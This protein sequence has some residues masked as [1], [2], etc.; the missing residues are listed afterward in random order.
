MRCP[1]CELGA[2]APGGAWIAKETLA[3]RFSLLSRT[4]R[5]LVVAGVLV[6]ACALVLSVSV[7]YGG[8]DEATAST[9]GPAG[10]E[11]QSPSD[12]AGAPQRI[13]PSALP[14]PPPSPS[15]TPTPSPSPSPSA[16]PS[17]TPPPP[18]PSPSVSPSASRTSY[19]AWAGP[20]CAGGGHYREHGRYA[21][22]DD[23]WYTVPAGGHR[24]DGCDGRFTAIPMSGSA[25]RDYGNTATWT[26]YV[27]SGYTHCSIAV[28]VP[29]PRRP[30]DAAGQPTTYH[31][32]T[33]PDDSRSAVKSFRIDQTELRGSGLIVVKVPVTDRRVTVRLV[34]RGIDWGSSDR[35]GAHH[36]A[37]QMRADCTARD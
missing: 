29:N 12:R 26:W 4:G 17:K 5:T 31:I 7:L 11:P 8:D 16:P 21:D 23:G 9:A 24:G 10:G 25:T 18:P 6:T 19:S 20:G 30:Q 36:A 28:T 22:G 34:D 15:P 33:D 13:L 35:T 3:G 27:G 32:L 1:E 37:A 2:R 14:E